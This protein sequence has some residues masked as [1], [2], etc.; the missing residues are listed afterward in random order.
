M[1]LK[2]LVVYYNL[3]DSWTYEDLLERVNGE[4]PYS[5]KEFSGLLFKTFINNRKDNLYGGIYLFESQEALDDYLASDLFK[6][7]KNHPHFMNVTAQSFDIF[8]QPTR[9]MMDFFKSDIFKSIMQQED[10]KQ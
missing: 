10:N 1:E 5:F 3:K 8:K 6:S 9:V 7:V 4:L 2:I